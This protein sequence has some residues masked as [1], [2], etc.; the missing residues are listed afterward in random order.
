MNC[1]VVADGCGG[2]VSCGPDGGTCATG[3]TCGGGGH[4][5]TCGAL[6]VQPDGAVIDGG[7]NICTPIPKATACSGLNCGLES[8]G[9]GNTYSCGT[10][11]APQT[12]GGGGTPSVCGGNSGCVPVTA[13][14][15]G[16][17]CG[18]V[19]NGCGGTVTCGVD[20]G[21]CPADEL[22]G[23]GGQPNVCGA[24]NVL[25]DGGIID[26]GLNVCTP[27]PQATACAGIGCGQTGDGCGNLYTCGTCTAPETC[28]GGGTPFECGQPACV[29][30]TS[31]PAGEQCGTVGNGCGGTITCPTCTAPETCGGGG[32]PYQCGQPTCTPATTCPAGVNCGPA[33]NGCGGEIASCGTCTAPQTC[34]G[35]GVASQCGEPACVPITSCPAPANCGSWPNGCGGSISCGTCTYPDVCGATTPSVCG[36]GLADGGFAC[37][38]GLKCNLTQCDGGSPTTLKGQ[39]FDP[40]GLNPLY[41]V[42]VYV[43][44]TTPS[45]L[46][47]GQ[48]SCQ[49]CSALYTGDPIVST[50]TDTDGNFT[51][52]GVPVANGQVPIVIQVGWWR[53]QWVWPGVTECTTNTATAADEN[54][55][56]LPGLEFDR[57]PVRP[58]RRTTICR[59]LPSRPGA[60]TRWSASSSAS[61]SPRPPP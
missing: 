45:A 22:C 31:C 50:T 38:A 4:P 58:P 14:P 35:G 61:A 44:N 28:G 57:D 24:K 53:R 41:N 25:P 11:T 15:S 43:P 2:L 59:R 9:C 8:D 52:T 26:G 27:I 33:A 40:A 12:C 23:G 18:I 5:N 51:L 19:A 39:I 46:P 36:G 60:P 56:R 42:V 7:L 37:D 1:G 20:G 21:T 3:E 32:V 6:N 16:M 17:N 49:A 30:L 47:H 29:P 48:P 13:C 55:L 54:Y 10:C 34:G